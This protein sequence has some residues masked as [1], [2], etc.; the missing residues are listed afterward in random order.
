MRLLA[1]LALVV[2]MLLL[3]VPFRPVFP[4]S[5]LDPSW[6]LGMNELMARGAV[7]GQDVIFTFGPLASVYTIYFHPAT[8]SLAMVASLVLA[9]SA[10]ACWRVILAGRPHAVWLGVSL[11]CW[12][13]LN[14]RDALLFAVPLLACLA[15]AFWVLDEQSTDVE[16][17]HSPGRHGAM[18]PVWLGLAWG[19]VGLLPLVKGTMLLMTVALTVLTALFLLTQRRA[20]MAV[21]VLVA[22]SAVS[23]SV[24]GTCPAGPRMLRG[25]PAMAPR[26][27]SVTASSN[28]LTGSTSPGPRPAFRNATSSFPLNRV[29]RSATVN[30]RQFAIALPSGF[31]AHPTKRAGV[32]RPRPS[33]T[34]EPRPAP[35]HDPR[36]AEQVTDLPTDTSEPTE[37]FQRT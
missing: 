8:D 25:L 20:L 4:G 24:L 27:F 6:M 29:I 2:S 12:L 34:L 11:V 31:F 15:T 35:V 30:A 28:V 18:T 37:A 16:Q 36:R 13:C 26:T 21:L 7:F 9:L 10:I 17:A 19:A 33:A 3:Y 1:P 23:I 5:G 32:S 22:P 14:S